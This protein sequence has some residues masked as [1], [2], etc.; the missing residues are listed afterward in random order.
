[1][2]LSFIFYNQLEKTIQKQSVATYDDD[3]GDI[4]VLIWKNICKLLSEK[5]NDKNCVVG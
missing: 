2:G 1:M 5:Q 3:K 4:I